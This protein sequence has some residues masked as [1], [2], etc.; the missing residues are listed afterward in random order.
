MRSKFTLKVLVRS[1]L[2]PMFRQISPLVEM[3]R[4]IKQVSVH[5][6]SLVNDGLSHPNNSSPTVIP[7]IGIFIPVAPKDYDKI[8]LCISSLRKY[9][10]NPIHQIIVC[11]KNDDQLRRL[12][13]EFQCEFIDESTIAPIKK[14]DIRIHINGID[15]SGWIFQQ[16]LKLSLFQ[17]VSVD[18]A[19]IWDADTCLNRKMLFTFDGV[20]VIEY[21]PHFHHPYYSSATKLLGKVPNLGVEFTCHK[22]LVNRKYMQEMFDLIEHNCNRKWFEAYIDAV[23]INEGSSISDYATY[24]LFMLSRYPERVFLQHWRNIAEYKKTSRLRRK[25]LSIWFRSISHHDYAQKKK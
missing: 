13:V 4:Q 7:E 6:R 22:L 8:S 16:I 18:N 15:R 25:M 1:C 9:L 20:S 19:L 3:L 23:D 5:R 10:V 2:L 14:R 12:C 24:S 11:G 17:C 21:D